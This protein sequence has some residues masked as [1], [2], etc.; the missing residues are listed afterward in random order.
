[1]IARRAEST[2]GA[3]DAIDAAFW[4]S[5]PPSTVELAP[6]PLARVAEVSPQMAARTDHGAVR[7][8]EVQVVHD[9]SR[10]ALRLSWPMS[11]PHVIGDLDQFADAAAVMFPMH[12]QASAMTM[13]AKDRPVNAWYW[14]AGDEAPLDVVAE[15]LGTSRRRDARAS[16]LSA[17]A[18]HAGGHWTL[19]LTRSLAVDAAAAQ[20]SPG[21]RTGIAFSIWD[22]GNAERA[23]Y[24]SSSLEF[25][26][27]EVEA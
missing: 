19:V 2:A 24:K 22:G 25:R 13:G 23:A 4:A 7:R 11:T 26:D 12:P 18:A 9:G 1:M 10:L 16:G 15:G 8:L 14:R 17:R 5:I 21:T 27:L 3:L 20:L 6:A